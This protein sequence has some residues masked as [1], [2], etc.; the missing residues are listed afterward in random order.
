[1]QSSRE[2]RIL[3]GICILLVLASGLARLLGLHFQIF[4]HNSFICLFYTTAAL[5][6]ARQLQKRLLQENVRRNLVATAFLLI[7]WMAIRTIKYEFLSDDVIAR[8]IWY[9][10]YVPLTIIPLLMLHSVLHIGKRHDRTI[11]RKWNLL[12][13][14]AALI[15]LGILTNDWHQLAFRFKGGLSAWSDS[16]FIRGPFGYAAMGWVV[17]LSLVI[18]GIVF[19]RCAVPG[20][21]KRIWVP[22]IPILIGAAYTLVD[23][24]GQKNIVTIMLKMPEV[25]CFCLAAFM[26]CLIAVRLFPS[27]DGYSDFWNA[28]SIGAGIMDEDGAI[29][30]RSEQSLFADPEQ[31]REAEHQA[32]LLRNDTVALRSHAIRGGYGYWTKDL[33]EI[34]RLNRSLADLGDV[35][36]EENA[37]LDA[38]NK[39]K[40]NRT[41]IEQQS[42]LY[43]SIAE[44]VRP[45]LDKINALL[46]YPPEEEAAFEKTMQ[47]ACILNCYVKR[48]SNLLMLFHQ[49]KEIPGGELRLAVSETAKY[50][51]LYGVKADTQFSG[52][53]LLP[54][55]ILLSAYE[56]LETAIEAAVPGADAILISVT[57]S[58]SA[59]TLTVELNNPREFLTPD[60]MQTQLAAQRGKLRIEAD[61]R[62]EYISLLLPTGG[63]PA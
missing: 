16:D 58:P 28:S 3:N 5:I 51:Q 38:E 49:K 41:R 35:I 45:Q 9:L 42:R 19:I 32:V 63:E 57:V 4:S 22:M 27:N 52:D 50:L 11:S 2:T 53:V 33:G 62:T 24:S 15:I 47:Y 31:I 1:M 56:L 60:C 18:L 7:F 61:G 54:G 48:R 26:E 20:H 37:M 29:R 13:I 36:A 43:D 21:R 44:S 8:Y 30:Y 17:A 39:I 10:Y 55:E 14:P 25:G 34:N 23:I 40:E 6:W 12:Y 59:L 46:E